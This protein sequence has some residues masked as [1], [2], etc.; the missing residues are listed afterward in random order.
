LYAIVGNGQGTGN[1]ERTLRKWELEIKPQVL[2]YSLNKIMRIAI[3]YFPGH[4]REPA[5]EQKQS[6]HQ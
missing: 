5:F 3:I 4:N 2:G 6:K 1:A